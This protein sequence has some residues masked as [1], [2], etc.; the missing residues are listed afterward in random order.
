M[1]VR[2][3]SHVRYLN[4][5]RGRHFTRFTRH[6]GPNSLERQ[7]LQDKWHDTEEYSYV[8]QL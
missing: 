6:P 2:R 4:V 8:F 3:V 5:A 7:A 1:T